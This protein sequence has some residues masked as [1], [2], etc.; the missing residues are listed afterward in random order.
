MTAVA[1]DVRELNFEEIENVVGAMSDE[2]ESFLW[3]IALAL[4]ICAL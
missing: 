3:G 4:A 2:T 1:L